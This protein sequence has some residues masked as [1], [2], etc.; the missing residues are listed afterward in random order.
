MC[1]FS[2]GTYH[3]EEYGLVYY[4]TEVPDCIGPMVKGLTLILTPGI[5]LSGNREGK[6]NLNYVN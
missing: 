2:N 4:M 3:L 1:F 6:I 5:Y